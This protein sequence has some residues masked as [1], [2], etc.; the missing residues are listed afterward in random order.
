MWRGE[1][2]ELRAKTLEDIARYVAD[3][4]ADDMRLYGNVRWCS[5]KVVTTTLCCLA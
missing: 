1:R 2:V 5:P 3:G 4:V